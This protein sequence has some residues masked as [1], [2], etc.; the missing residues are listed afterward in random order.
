MSSVCCHVCCG[1]TLYGRFLHGTAS[2]DV[3]QFA[4]R[5]RARVHRCHTRTH[6][7]HTLFCCRTV[8]LFHGVPF[9]A[10]GSPA[11]NCLPP[12][13]ATTRIFD[14]VRSRLADVADSVLSETGYPCKQTSQK[15]TCALL[16]GLC[17]G[18]RICV[19]APG[20]ARYV[21]TYGRIV[22]R[23]CSLRSSCDGLFGTSG[24]GHAT[25][26]VVFAL[27]MSTARAIS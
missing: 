11:I 3:T 25:G 1:V 13:C 17:L 26:R 10:R 18:T 27:P 24:S 9:M 8:S 16:T 14:C 2:R 15:T 23:K 7:V 21:D 4:R 12:H 20:C 19:G 6:F 22:G 5:R